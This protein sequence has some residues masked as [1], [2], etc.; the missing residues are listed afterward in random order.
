[1]DDKHYALKILKKVDVLRLEQL[2]HTKDEVHILERV[3]HP[4]IV[5][6]HGYFQDENRIY[7]VLDYVAGGELFSQLRSSPMGRFQDKDA[8]F[9]LAETVLALL[10]LHQMNVM[11]R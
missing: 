6:L 9:Y 2:Q 3:S 11:Y 4:F 5:N 7:L 10:H 8:K 1:M